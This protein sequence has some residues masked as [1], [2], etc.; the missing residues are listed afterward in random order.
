MEIKHIL[1][2]FLF[3]A[4]TTLFLFGYFG[5][6]IYHFYVYGEIKKELFLSINGPTLKNICG[7]VGIIGL[8][9]VSVFVVGSMNHRISKYLYIAGGIMI[10]PHMFLPIYTISHTTKSHEDKFRETF[11][12]FY[13]TTKL[14]GITEF[15]IFNN[16]H[17]NSRLS[18]T[19][20][21]VDLNSPL[22][23]CDMYINPY[24]TPYFTYSYKYFLIFYLTMLVGFISLIVS[25]I[26]LCYISIKIKKDE[27]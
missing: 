10:L 26:F 24:G 15:E 19:C 3:S 7:S 22:Y 25:S 1:Q 11:Y 14:K 16:C 18:D 9:T 2:S 21:T 5:T 4:L 12:E 17:S 8:V 23:C 27:I 20:M 6:T 13:N